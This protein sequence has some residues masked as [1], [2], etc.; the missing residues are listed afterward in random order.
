MID[1]AHLLPKLVTASSGNPELTEV[2]AKLA[3]ARAAGMGLRR[4]AIPFRLY[5][6]TLIVSV[7]DSIWQKQLRRMTAEFVSR[8]N[9]LLGREVIQSI[10]FRI[11]PAAFNQRVA[12]AQPRLQDDSP[13]P[14]PG[15][16]IS[17]AGAIADR[18]LRQ[19]FIRAAENCVARRESRMDLD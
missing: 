5:R 8:I 1:L 18:D 6:K 3:W 9:H 10:E 16:I 14:I 7:A 12:N 13:R 19:L 15:E 2:A 11:D 4:Q 17:A